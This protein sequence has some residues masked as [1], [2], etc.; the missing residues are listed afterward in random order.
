LWVDLSE[1]ISSFLDNITLGELI[2]QNA[3][4]KKN[5]EKNS[6]PTEKIEIAIG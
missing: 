1:R 4:Q 5:K 6:V 3:Q 2:Q